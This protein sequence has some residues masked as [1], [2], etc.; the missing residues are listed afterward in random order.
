VIPP[1]AVWRSEIVV[2][3]DGVQGQDLRS[4]D[5]MLTLTA[6]PVAEALQPTTLG[7]IVY[8]DGVLTQASLDMI[9][10]LVGVL[11]Q[12]WKEIDVPPQLRGLQRRMQSCNEEGYLRQGFVV[13]L[14]LILF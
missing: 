3:Q 11:K 7:M 2:L 12:D 5:L 4:M 1:T 9:V 6:Y 10:Y 14:L 8:Q 13:P